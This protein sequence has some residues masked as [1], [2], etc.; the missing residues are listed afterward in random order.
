MKPIVL[1]ISGPAGSG[2]TTLC[3]R[4]EAEFNQIRRLVTTTSRDPRPG[5]KNGI[6]YHFLSEEDFKKGIEDGAFIEWA[7]VHGRYY[8]SRKTHLTEALD[9]GHHLLFNV[10]VQ[11]A[12][13]LRETLQTFLPPEARLASIFIQP[14]SINQIRERLQLRQTD[15]SD[16]IERR[17]TTARDEMKEASNF[18]FQ[19]LSG[20]KSDDFQKVRDIYKSFLN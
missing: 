19:I 6:D 11:G 5:E 8:G 3:D 2:K 7:L 4:M 20:S 17:I 9:S 10:D 18:D 15:S 13:A 12:R 14:R 16:E 1:I